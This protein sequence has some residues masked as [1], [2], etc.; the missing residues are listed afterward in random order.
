METPNLFDS[1]ALDH[2]ARALLDQLARK[3]LPLVADPADFYVSDLVWDV[4]S[5]FGLPEGQSMFWAVR[6]GGT[7][8]S[9]DPHSPAFTATSYR[10]AFK[11]TRGKFNTFTIERDVDVRYAAA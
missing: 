4:S 10:A 8:L 3:A 6:D 2:D 1:K 11:I 7:S 5:L 9:F